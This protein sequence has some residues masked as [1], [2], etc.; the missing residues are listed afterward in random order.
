M[1]PILPTGSKP[2]GTVLVRSPYGRTLP[3]ALSARVYAAR[4]YNALLVSCR[5]TFGSGGEFDPFRTEVQDGARVVEWMREQDWYTG[6]FATCGGSYLG[7]VQW[8]LLYDP[9]KDLVA[10]V[11][12]ISP[13]DFAGSLWST[14]AFNLDFIQWAD[15]IAHQEVPRSLLSNLLRSRERK[16]EA[17]INSTPLI[18]G[19]QALLAGQTPW[20]DTILA[21]PDPSDPHYTPMKLGQAL[22][23]TNLPVLIITCWYDLFADQ[24]L[25]QYARLK[26]RGC[27]VALTVGPWN[28]VQSSLTREMNQHGF[29]WIENHLAGSGEGK[30]DAPVQYFVTGANEWRSALEYPPPT[31]PSVYYLHEGGVLKA[32]PSHKDSE[33]SKFTFDPRSPTPTVGGTG[34]LTG[35][36]FDD[37]SLST[38]KDVLVFD[39]ATLEED[40][41][42]CGQST[43]ELSHSSSSSFA[44]I[45]VRV[46]EV[47]KKG[48]SS[49]VTESFQR[50][51]PNRSE[52]AVIKLGLDHCAHRFVRGSKIRF[53]V[54][55][56]N[57]PQYVR[58]HGVEN[59][60]GLETEMYR[61]EHTI[62]HDE[63]RVSK[64]VLP[65]VSL[66]QAKDQ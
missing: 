47:N 5:G 26:Q 36:R 11:P 46:S 22:E 45:F 66:E 4:G 54:A 1:Q 25:E 10:A 40:L 9:P 19:M 29:N 27:N 23:R 12:C 43:V 35:G 57:F 56:G 17:A 51:D 58:N 50:L 33:P 20:L 13:H 48:K 39:T 41:E 61:V 7:F 24:S 14:G 32:E 18:A 53:L 6:T 42:I 64:V 37:T 49:N 59:S 63:I 30:R 55:G 16:L 38:R 8:A 31:I 65:V 34:L 28:H 52:S 44:D 21:K 15:M 62:Y 3:I 2:R 60:D